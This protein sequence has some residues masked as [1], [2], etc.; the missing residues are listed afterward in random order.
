MKKISLL[1]IVLIM[2]PLVLAITDVDRDGIPDEQDNFPGDFDNDGMPDSWEK[3]FGLRF[4]SATDAREDFDGDGFSNLEEFNQE[5]DP[6]V[7]DSSASDPELFAPSSFNLSA[8]LILG[9]VIVVMIIIIV[10]L[11]I[12]VIQKKKKK[13]PKIKP[14]EVPHLHTSPNQIYKPLPLLN[15]KQ[16]TKPV[17][18]VQPLQPKPQLI[19]PIQNPH[20][21]T[22]EHS[23]K[24]E[25]KPVYQQLDQELD[26]AFKKLEKMKRKFEN[27]T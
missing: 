10:I 23:R 17:Q 1:L 18:K 25:N 16:E 21:Q 19:Q 24:P 2:L 13:L 8:E 6:T 15:P 22:P 27:E 26:Y 3:Q 12:R 20:H 11:I 7:V 9:T 5:T 14:L 4:D